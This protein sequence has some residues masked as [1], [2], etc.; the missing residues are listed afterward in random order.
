M[1]EDLR[2]GATKAL[3]VAGDSHGNPSMVSVRTSPLCP[4]FADNSSSV[5]KDRLFASPAS[6]FSGNDGAG[7]GLVMCA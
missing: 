1:S 5:V 7:E 6:D 4:S 2:G 3:E